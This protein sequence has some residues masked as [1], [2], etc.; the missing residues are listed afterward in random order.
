MLLCFLCQ[1]G[2][3]VINKT[4]SPKSKPH[5]NDLVFGKTMSDH[6][7]VIDWTQNDGWSRP[8]IRPYGPLSIPPSASVLH[9][10][11]E[12]VLIAVSFSHTLFK[13]L[14]NKLDHI[15]LSS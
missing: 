7:L 13:F 1:S 12:V 3:L 2:D 6:M 8:E 10:G 5:E 11:L 14:I 9:Y 15:S 4:S